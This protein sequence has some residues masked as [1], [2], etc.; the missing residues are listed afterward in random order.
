MPTAASHLLVI[1]L[2]HA[3]VTQPL[4]VPHWCFLDERT[5][6]NQMRFLKARYLLLSLAE[7]CER[8]YEGAIDQPAAVITFDDGYHN[9]Y[10]VAFPILRDLS[11]PATVFLTTGFIDAETTPWFCQLHR[12]LIETSRSS[13]VWRGDHYDLVGR[14]ARSRAL[15]AL[16]AGLKRLPQPQLLADL[17][18][19]LDDLGA[20]GAQPLEPDSP[21]RMLGHESIAA[22][23]ASGLIEFGAHTHSH[24]ILSL[25]SAEQAATEIETSI[26]AVQKLSGQ[27]CRLFAYPN[28]QAGDYNASVMAALSGFGIQA[29]ATAIDGLND[30][31]TPP[32]EL[33]RRGIGG[34][35]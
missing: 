11:I 12:A 6:R 19:I 13:L 30:G 2:Y 16:Q 1:P 17:Q 9:N 18:A 8:L 22:M 14:Q 35:G 29:A 27:T 25:L 26:Q 20:D 23:S 5:F 10:E 4:A 24:A 21:F 3:I 32:L 28:G 15:A 33:R 7:A 31:L 34:R